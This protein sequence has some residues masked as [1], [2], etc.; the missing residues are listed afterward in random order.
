[1]YPATDAPVLR[2]SLPVLVVVV[3]VLEAVAP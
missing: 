1:M 3:Y 2:R